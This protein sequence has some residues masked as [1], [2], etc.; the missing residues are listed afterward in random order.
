[1]FLHNFIG[2]VPRINSW[3]GVYPIAMYLALYTE[4]NG[5][6]AQC[7]FPGSFG[8]WKALTNDAGADMIAKASIHLSL[9]SDPDI[10]GQGF[11]VAS[12]E[13]P[14]SWEVK[15][16]AICAWFGLVGSHPVDKEKDKTKTPGPDEYIRSH[17]AEFDAMVQN[18]GLKGWEVTSPTMD[19]S[20]NNWELT[21]YYSDHHVSLQKLKST[22]FTEEEDAIDSWVTALERMRKAKVIP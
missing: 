22:G 5:K 17:K 13:T 2:F 6:G 16:P 7:P 19:P 18:Y 8:A 12:T 4:I 3:N 10:K 20:D 1:M 15:W 21:K 11:N 9:L 14:Q